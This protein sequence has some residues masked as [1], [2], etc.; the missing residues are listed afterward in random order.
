MQ[1]G[2]DFERLGDMMGRGAGDVFEKFSDVVAAGLYMGVEGVEAGVRG[3]DWGV[4]TEEEE[5]VC[6]GI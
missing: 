3:R 5:E 4:Q 1:G 2:V 6:A